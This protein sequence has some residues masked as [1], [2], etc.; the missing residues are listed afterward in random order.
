MDPL[1]DLRDVF[2]NPAVDGRVVDRD[3]ALAHHLFEIALAVAVAAVP[4]HRPE[5]DLTFKMPPT[6]SPTWLGSPHVRTHQA[7]A[8]MD[9]QQSLRHTPGTNLDLFR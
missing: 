3:V 1:L 7:P 6:R 4:A 2:L 5:H 8:P 9:L